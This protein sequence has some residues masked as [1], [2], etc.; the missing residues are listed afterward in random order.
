MTP[1]KSLEEQHLSIFLLLFSPNIIS[2]KVFFLRSFYHW[3]NKRFTVKFHRQLFNFFSYHL[4]SKSYEK[5][6]RFRSFNFPKK[7]IC[8]LRYYFFLLSQFLL[9]FIR[10]FSVKNFLIHILSFFTVVK[11]NFFFS[12]CRLGIIL[13]ILSYN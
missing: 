7:I 10:F 3:K 9:D 5:W 6:K 8:C 4:K 1:H 2:K 11:G 12:F 13:N